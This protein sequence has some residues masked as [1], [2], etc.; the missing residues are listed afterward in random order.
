VGLPVQTPEGFEAVL[1]RL[2]EHLPTAVTEERTVLFRNN[3]GGPAPPASVVQPITASRNHVHVILVVH[4]ALPKDLSVETAEVRADAPVSLSLSTQTDRRL[5]DLQSYEIAQSLEP[6]AAIATVQ[7]V[8]IRRLGASDIQR[9]I[10]DSSWFYRPV[11]HE[12][13]SFPHPHGHHV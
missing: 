13:A 12:W 9:L 8:E 4:V 2:A 7:F 5:E 6:L 10:A 1:D 11:S 3:V